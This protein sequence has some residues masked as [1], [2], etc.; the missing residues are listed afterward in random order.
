MQVRSD[1]V[2]PSS[3][4]RISEP[5][6]ESISNKACKV[7]IDLDSLLSILKIVYQSADETTRQMRPAQWFTTMNTHHNPSLNT[8]TTHSNNH[9]RQEIPPNLEEVNLEDI[10][11]DFL[12]IYSTH[13]NWKQLVSSRNDYGQTMAH[14]CVTLGYFRLLQHLSTW[15]ID[16][17]VVDHMGL[18][19]LHYAYLFVQEE[20]ARLLI[21]SG[22]ERFILDDLGRSPSSLNPS[23]EVR[24]HPT[25]DIG[26]DSSRSS[27]SAEFAIEM[28]EE[29]DGLYAKHFLVQQ[30]TRRIEDERRSETREIPPPGYRG[31]DVQGHSDAPNTAPSNNSEVESVGRVDSVRKWKMNTFKATYVYLSICTRRAC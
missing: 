22:A 26:G 8:G 4:T 7:L 24:I 20:C 30:W 17:N 9:E 12:C 27:P 23:L 29:A 16:L 13:P 14:I 3:S 11:I 25:M 28:P 6:R 18:T 31:H 15:K 1:G 5:R 19:A 2:L 10:S 21:H